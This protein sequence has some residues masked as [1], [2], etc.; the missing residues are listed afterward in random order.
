MFILGGSRAELPADLAGG[1]RRRLGRAGAPGGSGAGRRGRWREAAPAR[2]PQLSFPSG[3]GARG[4][5]R[6]ENA[7]LRARRAA[8]AVAER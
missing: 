2:P 8:A 6:G 5:A 3:G 1:R 7:R 4:G